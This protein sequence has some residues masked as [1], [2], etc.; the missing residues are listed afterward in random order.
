MSTKPSMK[1][2]QESID[3]FRDDYKNTVA[4]LQ[5]DLLAIKDT[6]IKNLLDENKC[7]KERV[8]SLEENND[9]QQDHIIDIEKQSQALEQ[10]TCRNNLEISEIPN[11]IPDEVLE[12]KC[13]QILE[14]VDISVDNSKIE[15][16]H[17][18]PMNRRN[19]NKS[20]TVIVKFIN[21]KFVEAACSKNNHEKL[22][23]CNKI[24]LGFAENTE[25][26]FNENL[27]TYFQHLSWIC[28]VL[29]RKKLI[30]CS[31]FLRGKLYYKV[32]N[33]SKPVKVMIFQMLSLNNFTFFKMA[34]LVGVL[35]TL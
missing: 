19:K 26:F 10:Y 6:I 15:A 2:I 5:Q 9:E 29:K 21:R 23:S 27:S 30:T 3:S 4:Q 24:E 34:F 12:T 25:L 13:I 22:R 1:S 17:R 35:L 8:K 11:N 32:S 7:L 14:A 18:L 31:W 28:R 16:C 20:K 33:T